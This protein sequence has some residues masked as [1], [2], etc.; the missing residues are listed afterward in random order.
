MSTNS[1]INWIQKCP[2]STKSCKN[3]ITYHKYSHFVQ[4][5][6]Q[7][8]PLQN[9]HSPKMSPVSKD[10]HFQKLETGPHKH[11][12]TGAHTPQHTHHSTAI[13]STG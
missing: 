5:S 7:K 1:L 8:C 13:E 12:C 2:H 3:I 10:L 9:M 11:R 6:T 4:S